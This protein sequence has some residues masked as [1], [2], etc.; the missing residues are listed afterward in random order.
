MLLLRN[1]NSL[2]LQKPLV[3]YSSLC[4]A[5]VLL[6]YKSD[7]FGFSI[8][9][10]YHA[11]SRYNNYIAARAPP[12]ISRQQIIVLENCRF[13]ECLLTTVQHKWI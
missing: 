6:M 7:I 9:P 10:A 2:I 3:N 5:G 4:S 11:N 1:I 13:M 12:T 8:N